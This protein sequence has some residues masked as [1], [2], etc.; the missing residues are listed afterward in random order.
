MEYDMM[1][2]ALITLLRLNM[3]ARLRYTVRSLKTFR[4]AAFF[5]VA[6]GWFGLMIVPNLMM[7]TKIG[8]T[9]PETVR[10]VFPFILLA[11]CLLQLL[12][13]AWEKALQFKL[14]EVDF[15]FTGPFTRRELLAYKIISSLG[16]TVFMSL[17]FSV[18]FLRHSPSW[19]ACFCGLFF[20]FMF[21]GFLGMIILLLKQMISVRAYTFTRI[22]ILTIVLAG[23][24]LGM[25]REIPNLISENSLEVI[26]NFRESRGGFYLL[27][28]LNILGQVLTA[29]HYV[30][31]LLQWGFL[32]L[33]MNLILFLIIMALDANY[34]E[35]SLTISQKMY[36]RMQKAR[37]GQAWSNFGKNLTS[38]WRIPQ[39]PRWGGVGPIAWRQLTH[40]MRNSGGMFFFLIILLIAM[41]PPLLFENFK[42]EKLQSF[43]IGVI[44][45]ISVIFTMS[46]PFGFR[47]D[48][49]NMDW[50][51]MLPLSS[52]AIAIGQTVG[53]VFFI[54]A[55]QIVLIAL[56]ALFS[57]GGYLILLTAVLFTL[58]FNGI[59]IAMDNLLF[60][61]F[62]IR[63]MQSSPGDFQNFGRQMVY[64]LFKILALVIGLGI[65][66]GLGGLLYWLT[67]SWVL[68]FLVSWSLLIL[69]NMIIMVMLA[70]AFE[71]FDLSVDTPV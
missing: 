13:S 14:C 54:S 66:A 67:E 61:L 42:D 5:I 70:W 34:L 58:P 16:G 22:V 28:P 8:R 65:A 9:D 21:V 24:V 44:V 7:A 43:F 63:I 32:A 17:L 71:R 31:D 15:L 20:S 39:L 4:G 56:C 50:F 64:F 35:T 41:A 59:L 52:M 57:K 62:P 68:F 25:G 10:S 55:L 12:S 40:I 49:D 27:L 37:K 60:L 33:V 30:P 53:I 3:Y 18:I 29:E 1:H 69:E 36:T 45:W 11:L 48:L 26:K 46:F 2:P 6:V 51:K 47:G 19:L 23:F 38:R